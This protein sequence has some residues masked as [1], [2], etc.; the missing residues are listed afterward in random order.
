M[1]FTVVPTTDTG[2]TPADPGPIAVQA[3]GENRPGTATSLFI[4]VLLDKQKQTQVR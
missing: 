1:L 2:R 4:C 3:A